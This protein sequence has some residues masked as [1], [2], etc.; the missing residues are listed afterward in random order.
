MST[1]IATA[2]INSPF[3]SINLTLVQNNFLKQPIY[4]H[5]A[6]W[7]L[8]FC[9]YAVTN[10]EIHGSTSEVVVSNLFKVSLQVVASYIFLLFIYSRYQT[11]GNKL[12]FIGSTFLLLFVTHSIFSTWKMYYLETIYP[13]TYPICLVKYAGWS[14]WDRIFNVKLLFFHGPVNYFLPTLCLTAMLYYQK[15]Q[16][17]SQLNE[18][19]KTAELSILKH[20]LNPHFLFNTLNNLYAL[21]IEKSD[22]TPEVIG[23]LSDILDCMLYRC[24]EKFVPLTQ[25]IELLENY[26]T[27]EKIRYGSR[28]D[29]HFNTQMEQQIDIAPL[30]LLTFVENAFKHGVSQ[31]IKQARIDIDLQTTS[32]AIYFKIK[33]TIPP[34][35]NILSTQNGI[36]LDNVK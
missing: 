1:R 3:P 32:Q 10:W 19:K 28:V 16:Q 27:L 34:A 20:Q 2:F 22:K 24:E 21:A 33:N 12:V 13:T 14:I 4:Q 7:V 35:A 23:K 18:Q 9:C 25:E 29:V 36:G 8:V 26:I 6:F 15:Q 5:L 31:E 30:L 17:I 11:E